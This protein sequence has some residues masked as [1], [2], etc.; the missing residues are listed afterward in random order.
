MPMNRKLA[1]LFI[2]VALPGC[3][4]GSKN[5]IIL[6]EPGSVVEVV[7]DKKVKVQA[8][9]TSEDGKTAEKVV[10][11]ENIAGTV[12]MPKSV[13]RKMRAGYIALHDFVNGKIDREELDKRLK[14][15]KGGTAETDQAK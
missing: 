11:E 5:R 1:F 8:T 15:N 12:A 7:D 2:L 9:V 14:E 10:A 13:Y 6:A 3:F 4:G